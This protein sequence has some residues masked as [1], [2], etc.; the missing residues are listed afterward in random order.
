LAEP[1][2]L[3][4]VGAAASTPTGVVGRL[5]DAHPRL[6]TL[7][8]EARFHT[9]DRGIPG[10]LGGQIGIGDFLDLLRGPWWEGADG[11]PGLAAVVPRERLDPATERF[12]DS[13]HRDPI[14]ACRELFVS[15]LAPGVQ[16]SRL[17]EASP[18]NLRQ[19]QTLVR[20]FPGAR[21]VHVVRDGRDVACAAADGSG[22]RLGA[23][24]E[25]W[26]AELREIEAA[27]RGEED[28]ASYAIPAGS[29]GVVVLDELAAGD[30]ERSYEELL[31][32]LAL[33]D[34]PAPRAF[35]K[36]LDTAQIG[37][38]AWRERARG[39]AAWALGR[40]YGRALDALSRE[41]NHAAPPLI[42]AHERLG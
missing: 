7:P 1:G 31:A 9:D 14:A 2:E 39:P 42:E 4:F 15:V 33:E 5:L 36:R 6:V 8:V 10:L 32:A 30:R 24:V 12:R 41:G 17:V 34:D 20:L 21:F 28:G 19:A 11:E 22:A 26:A 29:V 37:R 23:G 40:R 3:I 16:E 13:Y 38:G 35:L 27:V 25:R 18:A